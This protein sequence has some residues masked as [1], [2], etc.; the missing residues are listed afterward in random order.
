[1]TT[2]TLMTEA[3]DTTESPGTSEDAETVTTEAAET[4]T[5]TEGKTK[6]EGEVETKGTGDEGADESIEYS[7]EL[8][9][10]VEMAPETLEG[11]KTLAGDMK[12][13][14]EGGQKLASFGAEMFQKWEAAQAEGLAT[15]RTEWADATRADK[16]IGG[17][18]LDKN[19]AGAKVALDKFGTPELKTLLNESGLGN[20]P[21]INRLFWKLNA[22]ISDDALVAG[23]SAP[24][25]PKNREEL[26][27]GT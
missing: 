17:A 27:Y 21:E 11:L 10:G 7:F 8:P 26:Y 12:L 3:A 2:E 1:M 25:A 4:V 5:D 13:D 6:P 18:D 20:H 23:N 19:L 16:E 9:E 15:L 14:Q 22:Q 24:V